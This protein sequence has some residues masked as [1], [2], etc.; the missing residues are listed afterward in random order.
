MAV[1][2]FFAGLGESEMLKKSLMG[3]AAVLLL[4]TL[5]FGSD[6]VSYM[7]TSA[8][9]VKDSV[10]DS[11]P[12]E[13]EIERAREMVKELTPE[14][15]ENMYRIA[16]EEVELERLSKRI[17]GQESQLAKSQSE[18][19]RLKDDLSSGNDHYYYGGR[20]Y[21][22]EQVKF[23]LTSRFERHKTNQGTLE[24][25]REIHA[26]RAKR[27][28]F[29]QQKLDGM[30]AAKQQLEVEI[31]HLQA[32]LQMV[33]AAQTTCEYSFDDS[34]LSKAKEL[35]S[36]LRT[37]LEVWGKMVDAEGD[38][39]VEIPVSEPAPENIVDEVTAYFDTQPTPLQ[40]AERP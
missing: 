22:I 12:V 32:Q 5:L 3:G 2:L 21:S 36:D 34:R 15:E 23:D 26:T 31:E 28:A 4:G 35:V 24:N 33:E 30:R 18:I 13:F 11:V 9:W 29:A 25:L 16:K 10:K 37:R 39:Y 7:T 38:I 6:V 8:R 1:I 17:A 14:I 27:L 20:S 40:V 19:M